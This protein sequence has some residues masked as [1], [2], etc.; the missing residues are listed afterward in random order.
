[1]EQ[2][3]LRLGEDEALVVEER[4]LANSALEAAVLDVPNQADL[5]A[6][7]HRVDSAPVG[8]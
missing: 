7:A 1:M 4:H 8:G 2:A 5:K 6:T 3:E